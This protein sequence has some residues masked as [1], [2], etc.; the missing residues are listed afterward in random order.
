MQV[1]AIEASAYPPVMFHV[2]GSFCSKSPNGGNACPARTGPLEGPNF[3][4]ENRDLPYSAGFQVKIAIV[5]QSCAKLGQSQSQGSYP[6]SSPLSSRRRAGQTFLDKPFRSQRTLSAHP[7]QPGPWSV[8]ISTYGHGLTLRSLP[9][10][11]VPSGQLSCYSCAHAVHPV[12]Q[13]QPFP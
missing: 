13:R 1:E 8:G 11:R 12:R 7:S 6:N 5:R 10:T 9:S 3:P 4:S 2:P